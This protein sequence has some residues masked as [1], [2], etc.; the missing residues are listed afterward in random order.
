MQNLTTFFDR[1]AVDVARDLIGATLCVEEVG[2]II[3][4]TEA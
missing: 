2:G 3:V 1:S 4:E